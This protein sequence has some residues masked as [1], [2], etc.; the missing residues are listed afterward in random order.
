LRGPCRLT[1][2]TV[3]SIVKGTRY[4]VLHVLQTVSMDKNYVH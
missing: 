2:C 4:T 1:V 3:Y